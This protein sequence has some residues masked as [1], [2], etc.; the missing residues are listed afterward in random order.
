MDDTTPETMSEWYGRG[1][2]MYR[3]YLDRCLDDV[4]DPEAFRTA[5]GWAFGPF[6]FTRTGMHEDLG[7]SKAAVGKWASGQSTPTP[8]TQ[9]AVL[10]WIADGIDAQ[11]AGLPAGPRASAASGAAMRP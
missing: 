2:L 4:G 6:G 11:I 3:A 8:P 1:L 9:K 10:M 7:I 5:L